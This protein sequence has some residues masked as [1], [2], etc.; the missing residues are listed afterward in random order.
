VRLGQIED[1]HTEV[2]S[3]S[4][5]SFRYSTGIVFKL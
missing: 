1:L 4:Q 3:G 5:D 2:G